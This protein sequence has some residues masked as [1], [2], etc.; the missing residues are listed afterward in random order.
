MRDSGVAIS[1]RRGTEG[2]DAE[3]RGQRGNVDQTA[4]CD[5][6]QGFLD[7]AGIT[8]RRD[9]QPQI[10]AVAPGMRNV[11]GKCDHRSSFRIEYPIAQREAR[12]P[13]QHKE[14]FVLILM[15]MQRRA[16]AGVRNN[17]DERVCAVCIGRGHAYQAAFA[18]SRLQPFGRLIAIRERS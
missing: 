16:V 9:P 3:S 18:R 1:E 6:A 5:D 13:F 11:P 4:T 8:N 12:C 14:I 15:D 2:D 7:T 10:R 17:L